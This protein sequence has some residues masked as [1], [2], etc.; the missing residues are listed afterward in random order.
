MDLKL[1]ERIFEDAHLERSSL[2]EAYRF[3]IDLE[4]NFVTK[5]AFSSR[6]LIGL[7]RKYDIE[8]VK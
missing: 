6:N 2:S 8:L 1:F 3:Q 4:I 7:L 5:V